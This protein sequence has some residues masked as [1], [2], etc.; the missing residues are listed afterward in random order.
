MPVSV[1]PCAFALAFLAFSF[2]CPCV[3]LCRPCVFPFLSRM[4]PVPSAHVLVDVLEALAWSHSSRPLFSHPL[5]EKMLPLLVLENVILSIGQ[6]ALKAV[7]PEAG[8]QHLGNVAPWLAV[9]KEFCTSAPT[10]SNSRT[11]SASAKE[12]G[13]WTHTQRGWDT[14]PEIGARAELDERAFLLPM[15][16]SHTE[17][18]APSCFA[19]LSQGHGMIPTLCRQIRWLVFTLCRGIRVGSATNR[20]P[21]IACF[22]RCVSASAAG[23][24]EMCCASTPRHGPPPSSRGS[25]L[26]TSLP[27][28]AGH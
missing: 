20:C 23:I 13:R 27:C 19:M 6:T 4:R 9:L 8:L 1:L 10:A 15:H 18:W 5:E 17:G 26:E 16:A 24:R 7:A 14:C 11:N 25:H 22:V 21:K 3:C 28:G 12:C 2:S